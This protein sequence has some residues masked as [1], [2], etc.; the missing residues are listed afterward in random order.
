M[1]F[2]TSQP[3]VPY[4]HWQI[5]VYVENFIKNG[6][7]PN[8]IHVLLAI[9]VPNTQPTNESLELKN[10]GINVHHY[11]DD[12]ENKKYI[13]SIKPFL[14]YKWLKQYPE[15]GDCFFLHDSD[16][17]FRKLPNFDKLFNILTYLLCE[18]PFQLRSCVQI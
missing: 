10:L 1:L 2:V 17:I 8:D 14:I 7:N 13:P 9:V 4:F 5:R 3:D 15:Y 18:V 6:I 11:F 16:I 12:R